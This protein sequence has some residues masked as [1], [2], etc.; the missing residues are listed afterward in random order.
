MKPS[1]IKSA[2]VLAMALLPLFSLGQKQ[3]TKTENSAYVENEFII[4]LRQGVDAGKAWMPLLFPP[5]QMW[6]FCPKECYPKG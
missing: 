3:I 4:W 6:G 2:I 5:T 1:I